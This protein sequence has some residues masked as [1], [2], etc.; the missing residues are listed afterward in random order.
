MR[1]TSPTRQSRNQEIS[2]TGTRSH[3]GMKNS[4]ECGLFDLVISIL[5]IAL[6]GLLCVPVSLCDNCFC[7][8]VQDLSL[9]RLR[10]MRSNG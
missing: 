1:Y 10:E 3:E 6:S 4:G 9:K 5:E 2:H 7:L 8:F